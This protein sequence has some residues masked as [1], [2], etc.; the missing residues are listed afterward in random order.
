M[1]KRKSLQQTV[2][3][4]L[5]ILLQKKKKKIN[6][7]TDFTLITKANSKWIPDL[8]IKRLKHISKVL[9][10]LDTVMIFQIQ[11]QRQKL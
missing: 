9:Y 4:Q 2:L 6:L 11:H 8:N 1:E 7:D 5:D 3:E 10:D